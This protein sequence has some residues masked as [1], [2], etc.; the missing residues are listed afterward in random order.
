MS[1][2]ST[3]SVSLSAYSARFTDYSFTAYLFPLLRLDCLLHVRSYCHHATPRLLIPDRAPSID[4]K[5]TLPSFYRLH[6]A[7]SLLIVSGAFGIDARG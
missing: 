3:A 7:A 1:T 6:N 2:F 5:R 4:T